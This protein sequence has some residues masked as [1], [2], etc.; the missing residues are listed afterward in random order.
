MIPLRP[1]QILVSRS[2]VRVAF[3]R[4]EPRT[5]VVGESE[6]GRGK[7]RL[8]QVPVGDGEEMI[9]VRTLR[10]C[11]DNTGKWLPGLELSGR[12]SEKDIE[13]GVLTPIDELAPDEVP[14]EDEVSKK[15]KSKDVRAQG[16][17]VGAPKLPAV[18]A[19]PPAPTPVEDQAKDLEVGETPV[20]VAVPGGFTPPATPIVDRPTFAD[21]PTTE[22]KWM[23]A[24]F[25]PPEFQSRVKAAA[26]ASGLSR[27]EWHQQIILNALVAAGF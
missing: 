16:K 26:K 5:I 15:Q 8:L 13:N 14:E 17:L 12:Y 18:E 22:K 25:F 3:V 24:D 4:R 1:N 6:A 9:V 27:S 20:N 7:K 2:G 19:P 10:A 23:F 21:L 11:R